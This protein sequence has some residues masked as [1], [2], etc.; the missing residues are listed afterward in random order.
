MPKASTFPTWV[1]MKHQIP[2][3]WRVGWRY[4]HPFIQ[5]PYI[6]PHLRSFFS[7][8]K[9]TKYA[10]SKFA[11]EPVPPLQLSLLE[12]P[13]FRANYKHQFFPMWT[14]VSTHQTILHPTP[15]NLLSRSIQSLHP[16]A[17]MKFTQLCC[18]ISLWCCFLVV[19]WLCYCCHF[20]L[21]VTDPHFT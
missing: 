14:Q 20:L 21:Q 8:K 17:R 18:T 1:P 3:P 12:T 7:P 5:R 2:Y 11:L 15:N 9:S 19:V 6:L 13:I 16:T 10:I 4:P